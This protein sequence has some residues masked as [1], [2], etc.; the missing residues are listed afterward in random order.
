MVCRELDGYEIR[1]AIST[2]TD[3]DNYYFINVRRMEHI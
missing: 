2:R 1:Y 3:N